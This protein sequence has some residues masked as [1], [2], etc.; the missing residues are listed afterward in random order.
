MFLI[1]RHHTINVSSKDLCC[2]HKVSKAITVIND[3]S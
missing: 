2:H 3:G 1:L